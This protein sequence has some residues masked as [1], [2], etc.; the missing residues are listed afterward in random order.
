M[1]K[2]GYSLRNQDVDALKILAGGILGMVV[3]MGIGRFAYTPILPLMLR[4]LEMTNTLGGLLASLNYLGYLI[5]AVICTIN[6]R[7]ISSRNIA[8]VALLLSLAT[9]IFMGTTTSHVWWGAMRF[10]GGISSAILF[11][12][13]SSQVAEALVR[14]SYGHWMGALYGGVGSGIA[15]SGLIVP[16]L[17]K[18]GGWSSAWTGMGI[19]AIIFALLGIALGWKSIQAKVSTSALPRA[20]AGLGKIRILA[21]AYFF[22]GLGYIVTATFIVTVIAATP[23][24]E[25]LAPYTWVVVG[26]S[27]IPSTIIWTHLAYRMGNRKTLL[28]AYALQAAGILISVRAE[29]S[30][31]VLFAAVTFGG[32]FLGIVA[33]T[34][35][36]GKLRMGREGGRSVA[37]LTASFSVGQMIGP[38]IAGR[39]AD[40]QGGFDLPLLLAAMS[41]ILGG[42]LITVDR[43]FST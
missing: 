15:I 29:S 30:A 17:D 31:E 19:I 10:C 14:R 21:A 26:I 40:W 16:Q 38:V 20:S 41:V 39:L 3:A 11:I 2:H 36:E 7:I 32:T 43:N 1:T 4:D 37:I 34:L 23:G 28:A 9:T 27:A 42:V 18:V 35:A 22:E 33:V 25:T 5:G 24:L 8:G 12:V 6:P 13:I